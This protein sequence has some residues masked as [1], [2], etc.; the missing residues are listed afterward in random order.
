ML[1]SVFDLAEA[2]QPADAVTVLR[3]GRVEWEL[4][5]R[6]GEKV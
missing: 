2:R 5:I 4:Q 6:A 1:G 3:A